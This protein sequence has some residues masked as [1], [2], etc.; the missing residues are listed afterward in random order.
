MILAT[1][2][3]NYSLETNSLAVR[4]RKY[5]LNYLPE[6]GTPACAG[7]I[8]DTVLGKRGGTACTHQLPSQGN[9]PPPSAA[10]KTMHS[11]RGSLFSH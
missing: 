10:V 2:G 5:L 8:A 1:I 3:S 9:A 11:D 6:D 4:R 7:S